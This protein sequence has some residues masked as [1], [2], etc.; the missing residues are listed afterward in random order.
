MAKSSIQILTVITPSYERVGREMVKR[1]KR[2]TGHDVK[3]IE[4]SD[5]KGFEAKLHL[6]RYS[7]RPSWFMDCDLWPIREWKPEEM[8]IGNCI[9]GCWD[10]AVMN[11]AAF[12]YTDC[13]QNGL[14]WQL[15]LNS[16]LL[17]LPLQLPEFR[18]LFKVARQSWKDRKR[19]KKTYVDVTDQASVNE[20]IKTLG[21]PIQFMPEQYNCYLFG[22]FHG[23]RPYIPRDII[24]L[25]GAGIPAKKK[26]SRLKVQASVLSQKMWPMHQDA[27]N[28]EFARQF[29]LR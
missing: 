12:P 25:H 6:D 15:Y 14:D 18:E 19:G 10:H 26:Y 9:Q 17:G 2:F 5:D 16:G 7:K 3:V 24:N 29:A 4:T 1:V 13:H 28:W 8:L 21:L 23:Q 20:A 11:P 22:I 27:V